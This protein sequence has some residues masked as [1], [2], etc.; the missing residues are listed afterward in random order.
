M[1]LDSGKFIATPIL[2][3]NLVF[4]RTAVL[5]FTTRFVEVGRADLK[6]SS[7]QNQNILQ[8]G[9]SVCVLVCQTILLDERFEKKRL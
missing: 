2:N 9:L 7:A 5:V 8:V 6:V 4:N 1:W 3:S